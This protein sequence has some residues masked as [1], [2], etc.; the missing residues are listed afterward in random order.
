[1]AHLKVKCYK[2]LSAKLNT[3]KNALTESSLNSNKSIFWNQEKIYTLTQA[4]YL[5]NI[6]YNYN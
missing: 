1:M 5:D 3:N 6:F 2:R 4:Y